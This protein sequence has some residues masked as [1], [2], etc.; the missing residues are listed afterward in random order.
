MSTLAELRTEFP[1]AKGQ[2]QSKPGNGGGNW[3]DVVNA[4]DTVA[5][6]D[7]L[8]IDHNDKY[9]RCPG[10][11]EGMS[12]S[13]VRILEH[14]VKCSHD[15]CA[16]DGRNGFRTNVDLVCR[17]HKCNPT[18][19]V[20]LLGKQFNIDLPYRG[21]GSKEDYARQQQSR[22]EKAKAQRDKGQQQTKERHSVEWRSAAEIFAPLPPA[23]WVSQEL[24]IGPGR[25]DLLAGY[26]SSG[27]TIAAQ[28]LALSVAA[29]L[30]IWGR[31]NATRG[32]VVH[33]DLEQGWQA[34][35]RRYQRLAM[36]LDLLGPEVEQNL[37]LACLPTLYLTDDKAL[38]EYERVADSSVL[39][40]IDSLRA[41]CPG[42]D[43]NDSRIRIRIDSLT[44]I[45]ERTGAAF[46]LLHHAGKPKE[47]HADQRTVARGSSAIFDACGAVFV[48]SG[49]KGQL[50]TVSQQKTPAD[51]E[52]AS[53]ADFALQIEDVRDG[54]HQRAGVRVRVADAVMQEPL[55]TVK[56]V[57]LRERIL[58]YVASHA[59]VGKKSI[60][61]EMR[62]SRELVDEQLEWLVTA[63][64]LTKAP[65]QKGGYTCST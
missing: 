63:G 33:V 31:F 20:Q 14:G 48:M 39:V 15:R 47:G 27:K 13:S 1:E 25:P 59:G 40:V 34:T 9:A 10:C 50:K 32:R 22:S 49:S 19:A 24:Q 53:L 11:G 55:Q 4:I 6:L 12:D 42:L 46:L 8:E 41:A 43:E 28:S 5:V 51:A 26:G 57:E 65:G 58:S 60:R 23:T 62:G 37:L 61:G 16:S 3:F 64:Q 36:G 2:P 7:W 35:A 56:T 21:G 38:N 44:R 29:G 45:S 54:I 18:E 30:P 17:V 52:G